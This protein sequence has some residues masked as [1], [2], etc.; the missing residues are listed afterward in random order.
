MSNTRRHTLHDVARLSGVSYQT[1]SR[2]INNQRYVSEET[3]QRVL[4][5]IDELDYRP[6]RAAQSLAGTQ[7]HTLAVT[8]FGLNNYG[9]AQMVIH[10]ERASRAAGYDLIFANVNDTSPVSMMAALNHIRRW[11][12]DG[13]VLITPII[14]PNYVEMTL[15]RETPSVL[16]GTGINPA[17]PS[18]VVDHYAGARAITQHLIAL[19]HTRICEISGPLA[20]FDA[21]ER[22]VGWLKT[23]QTAGLTPGMSVE[24]NWTAQSG[25]DA[26]QTLLQR[27][28]VFTG[29]VVGNDQMALGAMRALLE[30]GV[31][32]PQEVS[33]V[34][35]DDIPEA[36]F[37]TP[38]L[39]TIRQ[40]FD[41]VGE[42]AIEYLIER[43]KDSSDAPQQHII[44]PQLIARHSTAPAG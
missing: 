44:P 13:M 30:R 35:Y 11:E 42:R 43:I 18:V 25:Y 40:A 38:P 14:G 37:F 41:V 5:A 32:V 26:I 21:L 10:I 39:T 16:I 27:R 24:G 33:I 4:A 31:R 8:T 7:S 20:W 1:V 22:H 29:L 23:M 9:P 34:G 3:R 12:I 15:W 6:N 2:V 19:G 17:L 36:A 28:V